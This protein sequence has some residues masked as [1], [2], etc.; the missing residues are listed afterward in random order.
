[1]DLLV[2]FV[3]EHLGTALG[4]FVGGLAKWFWD[5]YNPKEKAEVTTTEI[6]NGTKVVELYKDALDDLGT[7]YENKFKE[8]N[9]LWEKKTQI[10]KEE[11]EFL[12][13]E[14]D[15]WK[16]K[17]NDLLKEHNRYKKEHP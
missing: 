11:I 6:E 13:R 10:L 4:L 2:D 15:L 7:R 9:D 17:Y 3:Q 12:K 8:L 5:K 1:M 14:R 16:K